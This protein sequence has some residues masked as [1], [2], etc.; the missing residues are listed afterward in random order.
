MRCE[1]ITPLPAAASFLL[2]GKS[3]GEETFLGNSG[4]GE[5]EIIHDK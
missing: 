5:F 4:G 3:G 1:V 2:F